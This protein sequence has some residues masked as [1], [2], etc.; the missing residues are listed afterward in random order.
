M[1]EKATD[2]KEM[3]EVF[4]TEKTKKKER[5]TCYLVAQMC[6]NNPVYYIAHLKLK[7]LYLLSYNIKHKL[8]LK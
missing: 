3:K 7:P 4:K 5:F 6:E 2:E 8:N 1:S